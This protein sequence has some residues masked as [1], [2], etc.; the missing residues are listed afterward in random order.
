VVEGV[1]AKEPVSGVT[2]HRLERHFGHFLRVV[3][4]PANADPAKVRA[5]L[6]RGVLL[7]SF[8]RLSGRQGQSRI[9]PI[10]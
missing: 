8:A 6:D 1:T 4:I 10:D 2:F 5:R 9:I 7:I 3:E